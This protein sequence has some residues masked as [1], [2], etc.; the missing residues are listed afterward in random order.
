M[1]RASFDPRNFIDPSKMVEDF[2][3]STA[4]FSCKE[5]LHN[6]AESNPNFKAIRNKLYGYCDKNKLT[7][8]G[9]V[10]WGTT[11]FKKSIIF[12]AEVGIY[13]MITY[14]QNTGIQF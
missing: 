2:L 1:N 7:Y 4:L 3:Q 14:S 9:T 6:N 11:N 8:F 12:E 5:A 13:I 10:D